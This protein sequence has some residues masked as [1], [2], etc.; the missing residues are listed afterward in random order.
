MVVAPG[1]RRGTGYPILLGDIGPTFFSLARFG[2]AVLNYP[3]N[4]AMLGL[5]LVAILLGLIW[6]DRL[7]IGLALW[8]AIMLFAS[9]PH[10]AS[11]FMD[12]ISVVI[13]LYFPIAVIIGWMLVRVV[14]WS[15]S[16]R[17]R[18]A[19]GGLECSGGIEYLGCCDLVF[20]YRTGR[21][22]RLGG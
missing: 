10:F 13:S 21:S 19:L 15:S 2:P 7:V 14:E 5:A 8:T 17:A 11:T 4:Y 1:E 12:T 6:R 20:N 16:T 22:V 18:V 3:T 9:T